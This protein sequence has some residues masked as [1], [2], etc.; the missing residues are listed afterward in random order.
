MASGGSAVEPPPSVP[1]PAVHQR[2]M[3]HEWRQGTPE[4]MRHFCT[5]SNFSPSAFDGKACLTVLSELTEIAVLSINDA[6]G[7]YAR[8]APR[9]L[10]P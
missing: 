6:L 2:D 7:M 8:P 10:S 4:D 1:G 3:S 5:W 9:N